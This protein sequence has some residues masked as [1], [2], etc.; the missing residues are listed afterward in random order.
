MIGFCR[1]SSIGQHLCGT[2]SGSMPTPGHGDHPLL[3]E[4]EGAPGNGTD[5]VKCTS[6]STCI[7][8]EF[9][10]GTHCKD[11][12]PEACRQ[13]SHRLEGKIRRWMASNFRKEYVKH[14]SNRGGLCDCCRLSLK[15]PCACCPSATVTCSLPPPCD[16][17]YHIGFM[18]DH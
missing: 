9:Q 13:Q 5:L 6:L 3:A 12:R 8:A 1:C 14:L 11:S 10:L 15:D 16:I 17:N 18:P 2:R 4:Q 7:D